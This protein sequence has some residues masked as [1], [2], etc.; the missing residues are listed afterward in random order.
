[1]VRLIRQEWYGADRYALDPAP[2]PA[3]PPP[4]VPPPP[5][6]VVDIGRV[7]C[8]CEPADDRP[9]DIATVAGLPMPE[10]D[11]DAAGAWHAPG[12]AERSENAGAG[13]TGPSLGGAPSD[14]QL[15]GML[16]VFA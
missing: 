7:S 5:A 15:G 1:M 12:G 14:I 3:A 11:A 4:A 6:A 9:S 8:A 2:P 10:R 16:D 13:D